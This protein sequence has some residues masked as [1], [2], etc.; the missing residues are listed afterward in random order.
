[1]TRPPRPRLPRRSARFRRGW[2]ILLTL[3]TVLATTGGLWRRASADSADPAE[4]LQFK[5]RGF[6]VEDNTVLD[7]AALMAVLRPFTGEEKRAED[8]EA[9]REALERRYHREGY[10]TVLVNIPEQTVEDGVVRLQVIESRIRRVRVNG[11]HYFRRSRILGDLPSFRTG[12]ILYIPR[13]QQE[14]NR[15]NRNPDIQVTPV[16][17]PGREL[18][19]IDVTLQVEDRLPLHGSLEVNNRSTQSTSDLRFNG[20]IRYDNLWQRAHSVSLQYQTSPLE[21]DEVQVVAASYVM[22][23]FW[24]P[25]QFLALYGIWSDSAAAFG[26]GFSVIGSGFLA[27]L[28]WVAPLPPGERYS[29]SLTVGVDYKDFDENIDFADEEDD[30]A[31]PIR[32]LPLSFAY[33]GTLFDRRG[34]TRWSA[35]LNMVFRGLVSD[36]EDFAVKRFRSR[37]NYLYMS[38]GLERDLAL[39]GGFEMAVK[40]DGQVADQPLIA[41]EQYAAGGMKSVRGYYESMEMGDNALHATIE[42]AAPELYLPSAANRF[43]RY[44][45]YLFY[46][47]AALGILEPL[48][49]QKSD[50]TLHGCGLGVKGNVTEHFTYQIDVATALRDAGEVQ[51]GDVRLHF[52]VAYAF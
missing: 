51:S 11:N 17:D 14:L 39:P 27:G 2:L 42:L 8:V 4:S 5:I 23:A 36:P 18:G 40:M 34:A 22:P 31:T 10:P 25:E 6:A 21:L 37:G 24:N 30:L 3:L 32:Y 45:P 43:V 13:I 41:N 46:D 49:G 1:M 47:I 16:L 7:E 19:T 44:R 15:L 9:A 35:G 50:T 52:Q 38:L 20:Q 26:E 29:H 12:E 33:N 48:P 28:R